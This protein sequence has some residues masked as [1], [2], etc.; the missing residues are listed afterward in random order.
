MSGSVNDHIHYRLRKAQEDLD[1]A[2]LLAEHRRWNAAVN[3]L[4]YSCFQLAG[5]CLLKKGLQFKTHKGVRQLFYEHFVNT[6]LVPR[7]FGQLYSDL[8]LDRDE[9]DYI[10][11]VDF[12][13]QDVFR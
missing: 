11:S 9:S 10:E 8:F 3:R 5:A 6:G 1:D 12:T 7:E 13:E 2:K 4:F